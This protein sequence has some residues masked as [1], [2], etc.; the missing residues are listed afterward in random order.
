MFFNSRREKGYRDILGYGSMLSGWGI[1][2]DRA[3]KH[4]TINHEKGSIIIGNRH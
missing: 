1:E 4:C 3:G 2:E